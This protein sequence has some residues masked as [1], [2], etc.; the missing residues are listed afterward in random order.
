MATRITGLA[1]GLDVDT[2]VKQT[3][4][5]YRTKIDTQQQRKDVL[6]IKQKLYRDIMNGSKEFYNKYFDLTKSDSLLLSSNYQAIKFTSS[7]ENILSVSGSAEARLSNYS[8]SGNIGTAAR[9]VLTEDK[10]IDNKIRINGQEFTL[11]GTTSR[12]KAKDLTNKL[13]EAGINIS[14]RYS[15]FAGTIDSNENIENKTGFIFESNVLGLSSSFII[16]TDLTGDIST[17]FSNITNV[18]T[19]IEGKDAIAAKATGITVR[20]L[21]DSI[22]IDENKLSIKIGDNAVTVDGISADSINGMIGENGDATELEKFLNS[23]FTGVTAEID[24]NGNITFTSKTLGI[25]ENEKTIKIGTGDNPIEKTFEGGEDAVFA[26]TTVNLNGVK[27]KTLSINGNIITFPS[28]ATVGSED[29]EDSINKLLSNYGLGITVEIAEDNITFKAKV[30]GNKHQI[31]IQNYNETVSENTIK[32]T[33]GKDTKIVVGDGK[34]GYYT[35]TGPTNTFTKD[36][37]T[38][39]FNS[40]I[41]AEG[42][43]VIGSKDVKDTVEKIKNFIND[44]NKLVEKL[45]K[46]TTEKRDR[47]YTPLTDEQRKELSEK[48]VELWDQRVEQGQLYRDSDLVR[49]NNSLKQSMRTLVSSSGLTLEKIGITPIAD[50][51][52]TANGTYVIN[53]NELTKALEGNMEEVKNLFASTKPTSVGLSESEKYVQTGIMYRLK[54][55]LYGETVSSTSMLSKKAGIEGTSTSYNN[56]LTKAIEEYERKIEDMETLFSSKEQALYTKY[57]SLESIMNKYNSQMA[58]LSQSLGVG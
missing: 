37:V 5:A 47:S 41:P 52:G 33:A 8:I 20:D 21:I 43:Q 25:S 50:Y 13:K 22:E 31:N 7:N 48:E 17:L 56:T 46:L 35:H 54:D 42:I 6:E 57:A 44:Y 39:N 45:N 32:S 58:Y 26:E 12:D 49:I 15:D 27:G 40:E 51:S 38:F 18:G 19:P 1:T 28:E 2:I 4:Q 55:I 36:G 29:Y 53:E 11:E 9:A 23:K 30:A 34:G 10:I 24:E 16:E 3:M 14:V